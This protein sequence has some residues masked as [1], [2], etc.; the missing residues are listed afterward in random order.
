[1]LKQ[2]AISD[3]YTLLGFGDKTIKNMIENDKKCNILF[4]NGKKKIP[5]CNKNKHR[6]ELIKLSV[7]IYESFVVNFVNRLKI[8]VDLKTK[9]IYDYWFNK[10]CNCRN[11]AFGFCFCKNTKGKYLYN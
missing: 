7:S 6:I 9:A 8:I 3:Y 4:K 10:T 11:I 5:K 1:M 2:K